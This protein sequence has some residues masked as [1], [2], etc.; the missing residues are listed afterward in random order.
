MRK[1]KR[2]GFAIAAVMLSAI[3]M[4]GMLVGVDLYLHKR[5]EGTAGYNMWGYRGPI[6][7]RKQPGEQRIVVLGASTALGYGVPPD[8]SI[9]AYLERKL[10]DARRRAGRG[11]VTVVNLA[12]NMEGAYSFKYTLHDY[13]YLDYDIAVLY[14]GYSELDG[15]NMRVF[16]HQSP[17]FRLTGYLPILPLILQEKAMALR[18]G[19]NLEAAY[20]GEKTVFRPNLAER[21]SAEALETAVKIGRSLERQLGRLSN[22]MKPST[23]AVSAAG[24][25]EPWAHYC[26]EVRE[27][28]DYALSRGKHVVV[29][30][31]PYISDRHVKQQQAMAGMLREWFKDHPRVHYVNLGR[32]VDLRDRTIAYDGVHLVPAGNERIAEGLIPSILEILGPAHVP[33]VGR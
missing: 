22:D 1:G 33:G 31:Q 5:Y 25:G 13:E 4:T 14:E 21:A 29:V 8:K 19:G 26:R 3:V 23:P 18:Y 7:K 2:V 10:N 24:C 17:I 30:T 11:P 9:P 15:P 20:R 6:V 27:A 28:V 32:T 12:W 16:R